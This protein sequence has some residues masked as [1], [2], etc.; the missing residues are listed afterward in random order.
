MEI[1]YLLFIVL[2]AAFLGFELIRSKINTEIACAIFDFAR[3][4]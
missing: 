3:E 1:I 4:C 2:L